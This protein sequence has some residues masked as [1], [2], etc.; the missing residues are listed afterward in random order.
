MKPAEWSDEG[1][2]LSFTRLQA[3]PVGFEDPYNLALVGITKGPKI[4]CWSSHLLDLND[5]V[6]I[7]ERNGRYFCTLLEPV[8]FKLDAKQLKP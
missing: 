6:V 1:K 3:V 5:R 8:D 4:V 7:Q 2:V